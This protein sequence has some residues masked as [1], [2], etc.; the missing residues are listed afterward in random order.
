MGGLGSGNSTGRLTT[1]AMLAVDLAKLN[2]NKRTSGILSWSIYDGTTRSVR[3]DR[4]SESLHL[5]WGG[6]DYPIR[7]VRT[8]TQFGGERE[9]FACPRHGCTHR[10]RVVYLGA[11]GPRCR[12]CY[13][14]VYQSTHLDQ[15]QRAMQ[16]TRKIRQ[17]LGGHPDGDFPP[18]PKGMHWR[19]YWRIAERHEDLDRRGEISLMGTWEKIAKMANRA[20]VA[21]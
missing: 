17:R 6:N 21:C 12:H 11:Q 14:L 10:C 8:D 7:L 9:W 13:R 15:Y 4:F 5:S 18:K 20:G 1:G 3:F 2:R 19:T 16:M